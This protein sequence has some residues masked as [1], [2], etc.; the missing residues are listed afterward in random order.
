MGPWTGEH[1]LL[2]PQQRKGQRVGRPGRRPDLRVSP[3]HLKQF[4]A[5]DS[6][7][8]NCGFFDGHV[9]SMGDLQA[10]NPHM[11]LPKGTTYTPSSTFPLPNDVKAIYGGTIAKGID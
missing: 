4:G 11:W 9:E 10:S 5:T 1:P 3:R 2:G 6:Y 8:L 7:R